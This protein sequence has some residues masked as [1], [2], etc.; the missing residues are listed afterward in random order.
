MRVGCDTDGRPVDLLLAYDVVFLSVVRGLQD[1]FLIFLMAIDS[2]ATT[3]NCRPTA[4]RN[5]ASKADRGKGLSFR[6]PAEKA[7]QKPA[8][9]PA[10]RIRISTPGS[11]SIARSLARPRSL[12]SKPTRYM[13]GAYQVECYLVRYCFVAAYRVLVPLGGSA[14]SGWI[15]TAPQGST[16]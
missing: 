11:L 14:C 16:S 2:G 3:G 10:K 6:L 8:F 13:Q 7:G 5:E 15:L 1:I 9:W 12:L 4:E